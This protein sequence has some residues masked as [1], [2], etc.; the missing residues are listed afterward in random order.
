MERFENLIEKIRRTQSQDKLK[1]PLLQSIGLFLLALI[2]AVASTILLIRLGRKQASNPPPP[3]EPYQKMS[4]TPAPKVDVADD[5]P[6]IFNMRTFGCFAGL[7]VIMIAFILGAGVLLSG[8]L[9]S[10]RSIRI[11]PAPTQLPPGPLLQSVP[12]EEFQSLHATQEAELN[13]YGW[14]DRKNGVVHIPIDR[15]MEL[16]AQTNLP[17][18]TGTPV[19][20]TPRAP[21]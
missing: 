7:L 16:L 14:V 9:S 15:A 11:T 10:D 8:S 17:V 12:G 13:S 19:E 3:S 4:W 1:V 2:G 20:I 5:D 6:R 21:Q 18:A